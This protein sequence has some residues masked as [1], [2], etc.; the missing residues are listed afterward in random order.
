MSKVTGNKLGLLDAIGNTPLVELANLNSN[1]GVK[2]YAK[3][4]GT[5]PGGSIKDR[6]ALYMIQKAE[7]DGELSREKTVV[8]ATSGNMGIALAMIGAVKGYRVKL[9]MPEC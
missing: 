4:E 9:F 6:A 8:E 7:K 5:N 3:V 1:P 2:L